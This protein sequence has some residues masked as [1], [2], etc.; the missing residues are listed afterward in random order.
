MHFSRKRPKVLTY[1]GVKEPGQEY[2][3]LRAVMSEKYTP[4]DNVDVLRIIE[5]HIAGYEV[6]LQYK[7]PSHSWTA[8]AIEL[9]DVLANTVLDTIRL[10][11][12]APND[13]EVIEALKLLPLL[14]RQPF[15]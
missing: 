8:I 1:R 2:P 14:R 13:L 9:K 11:T 15:A 3:A 12:I 4:L 5:P 10:S 6:A 7:A